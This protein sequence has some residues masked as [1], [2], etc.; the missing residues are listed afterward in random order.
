MNKAEISR[1]QAIK[2]HI[3]YLRGGSFSLIFIFFPIENLLYSLDGLLKI[4][5]R[6]ISDLY[7]QD[8]FANS[9]WEET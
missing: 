8:I 5:F 1:L 6:E 7:D 9:V 3:S 2:N 4:I